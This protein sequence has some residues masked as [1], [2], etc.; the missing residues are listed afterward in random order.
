MTPS[1]ILPSGED[2]A[3]KGRMTEVSHAKLQSLRIASNGA[4]MEVFVM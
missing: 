3:Q 1:Y 2:P 4:V